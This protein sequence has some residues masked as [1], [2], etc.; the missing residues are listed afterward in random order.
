MTRVCAGGMTGGRFLRVGVFFMVAG[1]DDGIFLWISVNFWLLI[2]NKCD[3]KQIIWFYWVIVQ[4]YDIF[5]C[6]DGG[7]EDFFRSFGVIR[8]G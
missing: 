5:C 2:W 7:S 4:F 8:R 6:I 3:I 1:V